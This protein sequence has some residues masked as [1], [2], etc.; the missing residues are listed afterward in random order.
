MHRLLTIDEAAER[1][2]VP[3]AALRSEAERHGYL[4]RM[5]RAVRIDPNDLEELVDKCRD[6]VKA[7]DLSGARMASTASVTGNDACQRARETAERLKASSR[8]TS[9]N[10]TGPMAPQS[11]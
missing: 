11:R 6:Q 8:R 5:G 10:G 7:P 1:L 4:V 2:G 3:R 9:P